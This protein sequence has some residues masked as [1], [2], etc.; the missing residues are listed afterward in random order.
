MMSVT[1]SIKLMVR[2]WFVAFLFPR[3]LV[4]IFYLPKYIKNY[5]IYRKLSEKEKVDFVDTYPCL[6]DGTVSTP[7]DGHYFFQGA[8]LARFIAKDKPE[9]HVDVGSSVMMISVLSA[10]VK[11]V[12]VDYR[13]L[14]VNLSGLESIGANITCLPFQSGSLSSRS[15]QHVI[16]HIG[17]GRYGDPLDS[18]GSIKAAIELERVL[19]VGGKLYLSLPV[20]RERVC[21]NAHRVHAP[22][23]VM[24]FFKHMKLIEFSYV[25]DYGSYIEKKEPDAASACEYACGMFLFEK[26]V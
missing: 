23:T 24:E 6:L 25:D 21:F 18:E 12:F 5:L 13:P 2:N 9:L 11:T 10:M 16:E 7:F 20:G 15:C 8:W 3:P 17:F 4:G 19:K 22:T 26:G 14:Q 1:K